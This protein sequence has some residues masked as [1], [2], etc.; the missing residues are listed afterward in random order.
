MIFANIWR[1]VPFIAITL[2]AGLQTVSP[3]LYEAATIDGATPLADV[4]LRHLSA[5]H[6]DHRRGDDLLGAVHLHRFPADLGADPR[7]PGQRHAADGDA[8]LQRAI[9]GG[10]LG[11]GAA[12]STAM[13]PFLL[14]AILISWFGLQRRK[15]QQGESN[16]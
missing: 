5:A 1:G 4:P 10:H 14:A 3:S 11:E 13:M 6:A 15:W 12:I 2:L 9:L 8:V 7:R 16:D